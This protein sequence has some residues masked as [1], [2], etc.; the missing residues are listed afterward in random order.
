M[1]CPPL[2]DASPAFVRSEVAARRQ[3]TD[4]VWRCACCSASAYTVGVG[5]SNFDCG[6]DAEHSVTIVVRPLTVSYRPSNAVCG[7]PTLAI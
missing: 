5:D 7:S 2:R 4:G 6:A 3:R 1:K